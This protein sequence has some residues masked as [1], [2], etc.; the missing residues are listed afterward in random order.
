MRKHLA[1]A[2]RFKF[3]LFHR[4]KILSPENRTSFEAN[5]TAKLSITSSAVGCTNAW[6][7][8]R[9]F[10]YSNEKGKNRFANIK[11]S[12]LENV[13]YNN[14]ILPRLAATAFLLVV[15]EHVP[16]LAICRLKS[17]RRAVA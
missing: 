4:E 14:D 17:Y 9:H 13:K 10:I 5:K 7:S 6:G 15:S 3:K 12:T 8:A 2:S 16:G 1:A 11:R